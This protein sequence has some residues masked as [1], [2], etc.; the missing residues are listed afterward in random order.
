MRQK[1]GGEG[2]KRGNARKKGAEREKREERR[3]RKEERKRKKQKQRGSGRKVEEKYQTK[4]KGFLPG[5]SVFDG[6]LIDR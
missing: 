3:G 5:P 2:E 6:F 4:K 1:E